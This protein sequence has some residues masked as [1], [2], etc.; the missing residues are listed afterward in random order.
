MGKRRGRVKS[1]NMYIGPV[2]GEGWN[3]GGE[4]WVG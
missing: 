3:V 4:W 1:R 2:V